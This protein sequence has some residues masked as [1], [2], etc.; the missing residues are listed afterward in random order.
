MEERQLKNMRI[1]Y[2]LNPI[3]VYIVNRG[4]V[5]PKSP[6]GTQIMIYINSR[7]LFSAPVSLRT[8]DLKGTVATWLFLGARPFP[9]KGGA[10]KEPQRKRKG[11]GKVKEKEI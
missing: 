1:L 7:L 4:V 2:T 11:K 6:H 9:E 3:V 10:A 8:R 5:R